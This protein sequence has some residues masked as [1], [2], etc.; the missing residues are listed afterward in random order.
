MRH[1]IRLCNAKD[2]KSKFYWKLHEV[3]LKIKHYLNKFQKGRKK[4]K[5]NIFISEAYKFQRSSKSIN[6]IHQKDFQKILTRRPSAFKSDNLSNLV[7][8]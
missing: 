1:A 6:S 7:S 2:G 3:T 4:H 5:M 8:K